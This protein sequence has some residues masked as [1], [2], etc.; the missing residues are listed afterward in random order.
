MGEVLLDFILKNFLKEGGGKGDLE[1][2]SLN[3]LPSSLTTYIVR[4]LSQVAD[5]YLISL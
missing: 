4:Y 3:Y 1:I 2:I 5:N